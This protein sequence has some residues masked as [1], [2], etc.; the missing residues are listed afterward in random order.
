MT[1]GVD[2]H[3]GM[4]EKIPGDGKLSQEDQGSYASCERWSPG[5]DDWIGGGKET[6]TRC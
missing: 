5:N 1:L 4:E 3:C 6:V 2:G